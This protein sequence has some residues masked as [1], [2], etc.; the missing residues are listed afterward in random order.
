MPVNINAY[1]FVYV[2]II[3]DIYYKVIL[4]YLDIHRGFILRPNP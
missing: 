4:Y 1:L 2:R 3:C